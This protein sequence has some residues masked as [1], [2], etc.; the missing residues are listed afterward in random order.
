V[1]GEAD[2]SGLGV[3]HFEPIVA[4][5]EGNRPVIENLFFLRRAA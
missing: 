3:A 4:R 5:Y 2:A 1:E